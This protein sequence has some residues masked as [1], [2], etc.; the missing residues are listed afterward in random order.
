M[1]SAQ[2]SYTDVKQRLLSISTYEH[3]IQILD[4][5]NRALII[6]NH[7]QELK[8]MRQKVYDI[9]RR[10]KLVP[11]FDVPKITENVITEAHTERIHTTDRPAYAISYEDISLISAYSVFAICSGALIFIQSLE[12]YSRATFDHPILATCGALLLI[13]AA[14]IIRALKPGKLTLM[15]CIYALSYES[16][17]MISGT[18]AAESVIS[19]ESVASD[20]RLQLL[21]MQSESA[22]EAYEK[23]KSTYESNKNGWY[24][25]KYVD[26]AK[27]AY[28]QSLQNI[29]SISTKENNSNFS[30]LKILYRIGLLFLFSISLSLLI[31]RIKIK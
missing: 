16:Y 26:P 15:L 6:D 12:I 29:A 11:S 8:S 25:V 17:L 2:K 20:P 24:K 19:S 21:H 27:A 10:L 30:I 3:T 5:I 14:S 18:M 22:S 13:C 1:Q 31:T 9:R 28:M 7:N 4:Y 23:A